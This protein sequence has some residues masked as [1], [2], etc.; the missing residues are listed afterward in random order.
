MSSLL[1]AFPCIATGIYG[2]R[3]SQFLVTVCVCVCVCVTAGYPHDEAAELALRV[4][5]EWLKQH[6]DKVGCYSIQRL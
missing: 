2:E 4:T 6:G 1:Q 3:S 5:R